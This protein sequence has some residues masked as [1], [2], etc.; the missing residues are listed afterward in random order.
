MT[1]RVETGNLPT[2][3]EQFSYWREVVCETW[4]GLWAERRDASPF[5]AMVTMHNV[6]GVQ[7]AFAQLPEHQLGR[8]SPGVAR[9]PQAAY[10]LHQ[11]HEG[12]VRGC[13]HGTEYE[14]GP[15]DLLLF[16]TTETCEGFT[17]EA[18]LKTTILHLPHAFLVS[19]LGAAVRP[20]VRLDGGEGGGALLAGYLTSLSHAA[21]TLPPGTA[22]KASSVLCDLIAVAFKCSSVAMENAQSSIRQARLETAQAFMTTN[23]A[24]PVLGIGKVA[25]HLGVSERYVQKLFEGTGRTFSE[26]LLDARLEACA[27]ALHSRKEEH[28]TIAD[29][30]FKYGFSDLSWFYRRYRARWGETPGDTRARVRKGGCVSHPRP[31][32]TNR[33]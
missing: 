23:L 16:D 2:P 28:R 25:R 24:D 21:P 33:P 3:A 10:C 6:G 18:R 7:M 8:S 15:G 9:A 5:D 27:R 32:C 11:I 1:I 19:H 4:F 29:L 20:P 26:T 30:A 22:D 13:Y 17:I 12:R 31:P 14:A